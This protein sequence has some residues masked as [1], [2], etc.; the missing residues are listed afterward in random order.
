MKVDF[1]YLLFAYCLTFVFY[2]IF[3][4]TSISECVAY[5]MHD[6]SINITHIWLIG[7]C[8]YLFL[9]PTIILLIFKFN[10]LEIPIKFF[11]SH[12]FISLTS[13]SLLAI[14]INE[15]CEYINDGYY[16]FTNTTI[17]LGYYLF[18]LL[19]FIIIFIIFKT[20]ISSVRLK[21]KQILNNYD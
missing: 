8:C 2:I 11:I 20:L 17:T 1:R 14:S 7:Y 3:I 13:I 12:F 6:A 19:S 18:K 10:Q 9:L 5:W 16:M 4:L 15:P 21:K